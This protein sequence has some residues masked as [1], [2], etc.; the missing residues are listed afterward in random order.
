MVGG[1][2][3][4]QGDLHISSVRSTCTE[5]GFAVLAQSEV[6]ARIS[7]R[8]IAYDDPAR[9]RRRVRIDQQDSARAAWSK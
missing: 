4:K 6:D 3:E 9:G 7:E 1:C 2:I 5:T 8:E